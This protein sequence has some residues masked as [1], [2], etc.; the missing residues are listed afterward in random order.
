MVAFGSGRPRVEAV[1]RYSHQQGDPRDRFADLQFVLPE[2][3]FVR[4]ETEGVC[5]CG[6]GQRPRP[7]HANNPWVVGYFVNGHAS[8]VR[9]EHGL[10]HTY[11][12]TKTH[13]QRMAQRRE[14][15]SRTIDGRAILAMVKDHIAEHHDGSLTAFCRSIGMPHNSLSYNY[16]QTSRMT[17]Q[18]AVQ[19]LQAIGEKPHP[20]LLC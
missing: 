4:W 20:S 16:R 11:S 9:R 13:E 5:L 10:T 17:K 7:R 15:M 8:A 14:N 18:R 6:C 19:L 12:S 3:N 2:E 1:A